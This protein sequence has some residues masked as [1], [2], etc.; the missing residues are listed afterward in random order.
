LQPLLFISSKTTERSSRHLGIHLLRGSGNS[1]FE[2]RH[3][4]TALLGATSFNAC[5]RAFLC[6]LRETLLLVRTLLRAFFSGRAAAFTLPQGAVLWI[7]MTHTPAALEAMLQGC[8]KRRAV[9]S[10]RRI[11]SEA[12]GRPHSDSRRIRIAKRTGS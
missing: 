4:L 2:M 10:F 8:K 9:N 11:L 1:D 5:R 12:A 6:G 3:D 7:T